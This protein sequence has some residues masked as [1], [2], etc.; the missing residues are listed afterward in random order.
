MKPN[1]LEDKKV[2]DISND[3]VKL[4][5]SEW[6]FE[7][8]VNQQHGDKQYKEEPKAARLPQDI[9]ARRLQERANRQTLVR[10]L[11]S[12]QRHIEVK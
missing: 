4:A 1:Q 5:L 11:S 8:F 7:R 9:K 2:W 3:S 10:A 6:D 12:T